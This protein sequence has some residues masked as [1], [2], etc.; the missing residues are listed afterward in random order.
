MRNL[1]NEARADLHDRQYLARKMLEAPLGGQFCL[2]AHATPSSSTAAYSTTVGIPASRANAFRRIHAAHPQLAAPQQ[3]LT[4]CMSMT[5]GDAAGRRDALPVQ[6]VRCLPPKIPERGQSARSPQPSHRAAALG[7]PGHP[8]RPV[9][10]ARS[11]R[12]CWPSATSPSSR[13]RK[14]CF[15][16]GRQEDER[17]SRYFHHVLLPHLLQND[18]LVRNVLRAVTRCPVTIRKARQ[19]PSVISSPN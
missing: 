4:P 11:L 18:E 3:R 14:C 17:W 7:E 16:A 19:A 8:H 5:R 13:R 2:P 9:A 6:P 15:R 1:T 12:W 10:A